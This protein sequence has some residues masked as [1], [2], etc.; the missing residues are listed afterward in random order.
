MGLIGQIMSVIFGDGRNAVTE[1]LQV[2]RE[3]AENGA[4]RDADVKSAALAQLAA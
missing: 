3:K 4:V 2:F 1:T